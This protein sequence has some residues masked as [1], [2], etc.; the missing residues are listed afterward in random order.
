MMKKPGKFISLLLTLLIIAGVGSSAFHLHNNLDTHLE[1]AQQDIVQD[2]N[3]CTLCAS[4][5]K[6]LSETI[7][8]DKEIVTFELFHFSLPGK[9]YA[10]PV[11]NTQNSRAPPILS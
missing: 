6:F 4:Q 1:D 8:E 5:F 2:H 3:F 11:S 9:F 10:D 7:F